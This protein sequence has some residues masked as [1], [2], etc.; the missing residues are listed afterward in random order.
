MMLSLITTEMPSGER[1]PR[2]Q[3]MNE[4]VG[5]VSAVEWWCWVLQCCGG[6][7]AVSNSLG[8]LEAKMTAVVDTGS[9]GAER[10]GE[11]T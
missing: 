8:G 7:T 2:Q 10:Y 1:Q 9:S 11:S 6:V 3:G 5:V 4:R